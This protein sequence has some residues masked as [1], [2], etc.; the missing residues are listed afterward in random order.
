MILIRFFFDQYLAGKLRIQLVVELFTGLVR[1]KMGFIIKFL[2]NFM[3]AS[4]ID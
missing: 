2:K 3:K 4:M 1:R